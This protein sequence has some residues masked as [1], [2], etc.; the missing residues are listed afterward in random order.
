MQSQGREEVLQTDVP[1]GVKM[2]PQIM[3]RGSIFGDERWL[4]GETPRGDVLILVF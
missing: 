3:C 1:F 2:W 4:L